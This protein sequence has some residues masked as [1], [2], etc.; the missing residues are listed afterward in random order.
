[1]ASQFFE[2][3]DLCA[4]IPSSKGPI[5]TVDDVSL[6][7]KEKECFGLLGESGCGKT[8]LLTAALGFFQ[9]SHRYKDA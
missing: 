8:S 4:H 6:T 1:M 7:L 9:I 5:V 2:I 3:R